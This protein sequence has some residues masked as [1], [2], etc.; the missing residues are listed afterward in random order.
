MQ[1]H[2]SSPLNRSRQ[3]IFLHFFLI[4]GKVKRGKT[5][6]FTV[7]S[8][9]RNKALSVNHY[10]AII[11]TEHSLMFLESIWTNYIIWH[12]FSSRKKIFNSPAEVTAPRTAC[13]FKDFDNLQRFLSIS[14]EQ[15][16]ILQWPDLGIRTNELSVYC[17]HYPVLDENNVAIHIFNEMS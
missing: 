9:E 2:S 6:R 8:T 7:I 16:Y 1:Q 13:P 5:M 3:V 15:E 10:I 4:K 12:A 17:S 14:H 11:M